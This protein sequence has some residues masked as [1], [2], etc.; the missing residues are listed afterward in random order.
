MFD[1]NSATSLQ[2]LFGFLHYKLRLLL[3]DLLVATLFDQRQ[4][5]AIETIPPA[6]V[7]TFR[8]AHQELG[9]LLGQF[10]THLLLNFRLREIPALQEVTRK[11]SLTS[12]SANRGGEN[13]SATLQLSFSFFFQA[14]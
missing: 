2:L 8:T 10:L 7:L 3:G 9:L 14:R 11:T 6:P 4:L 12:T 1:Q 13:S 5:V